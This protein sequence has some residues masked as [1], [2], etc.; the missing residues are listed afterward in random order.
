MSSWFCKISGETSGPLS[1][2]ELHF[3]VERGRL[4]ADDLVSTTPD[5]GWMP[6][7][8]VKG[9]FAPQSKP[10][11]AVATVA[12]TDPSDAQPEAHET[13]ETQPPEAVEPPA[14]P[15][16][17][18]EGMDPRKKQ[19]II[20]SSVGAAVALLILLLLLWLRSPGSSGTGNAAIAGAG[21]GE[22]SGVGA[23]EVDATGG[24]VPLEE[25]ES[26]E[27][28]SRDVAAA[29]NQMPTASSTPNAPDA[30]T[31]SRLFT[32]QQLPRTAAQTKQRK[33]SGRKSRSAGKRGG[34]LGDFGERLA[35]EGAKS[36]DVQVS[37]I[38]NNTN[39]L[40]LHVMCPSGE[41]IYFR[42]KRSCGGELD[43]D[44]NASGTFSREPVENIVWADTEAPEGT[45]RVFVHHYRNNGNADP[46]KFEIAVTVNGGTKKI[47]G[48]VTFGQ[49]RVL[50]HEFKRR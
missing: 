31:T 27:G 36:G 34:G 32:V 12:Q 47:T 42:N 7:G 50:V 16:P 30:K 25:E 11:Q 29:A 38:W 14:P 49:A 37:L 35:R 1:L 44:M 46:T 9:L 40:D 20:G 39:D 45:Y 6:A 41:R 28:D 17:A 24:A 5:G 8:S 2:E 21:A 4:A 3:L 13:E 22:E 19:A 10:V 26:D 33:R 15:S 48:Q 18:S 43:V 23:T